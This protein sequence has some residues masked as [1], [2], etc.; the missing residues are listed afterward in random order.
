MDVEGWPDWALSAT[1]KQLPALKAPQAVN[2]L[3]QFHAYVLGLSRD[4]EPLLPTR[5]ASFAPGL[6]FG[7]AW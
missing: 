4:C 2:L 7:R 1:L 6:D 3:P 5:A